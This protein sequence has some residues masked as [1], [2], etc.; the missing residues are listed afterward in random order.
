MVHRCCPVESGGLRETDELYRNFR[1][2][3][4]GIEPLLRNRGFAKP[5]P[6]EG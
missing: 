1:G 5:P 6:A 4:P 2:S 3:D